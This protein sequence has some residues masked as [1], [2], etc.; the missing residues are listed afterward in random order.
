[1][2]PAVL[3][4]LSLVVTGILL[5]V[6]FGAVAAP[7]ATVDDAKTAG[8]GIRKLPGKR[9]T[10]YT[11]LSGAEIDQL[12]AVFEQAFPQW[13][14]YFGVQES[15]HPDWHMTGFLMKDKARFA[16]AGL[17]LEELPPFEHG[18]SAGL[19]LWLYEQPSDY[20]RRHLLLHEG[21]HGFM[22][23]VLGGWGRLWYMEGMAEYLATH[24]WQ[25]GQ[26]TLGYM[27]RSREEVPQWG[28]IRIIQDAV[29][30]HRALK[31][32]VVT[33]FQPSPH[34]D[35]DLYAW[36]WA[37]ATL[38]DRHPRYQAR[39]RDL[40]RLVNQPD[41]QERFYGAF[42]ADWQELS[43]E[44]QLMVA[45]LEYGYDVARSTI[46]FKPGTVSPRPLG[47][48]KG[49]NAADSTADSPTFVSVVADRGWQNTGLRLEAG[50]N[51][52][53]KATGRY[54]IAR[55]TFRPHAGDEQPRRSAGLPAGEGPG[56]RATDASA[57]LGVW[58]CEPNGVSIR[59]YQGR[60]LGIL[61]AAVRPDNPPLGSTSVLLRP[62]VVGLG[63]T[64]S[65]TESGT[66]FLKINDSVGELDDN[67]GELKVEVRPE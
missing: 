23:S 22:N 26:L 48:K 56:E 15:D 13:C 28:R 39:F 64:L 59:Y 16:E 30:A 52:H 47:E 49:G 8:A 24:R 58:W 14:K 5:W 61:L 32:R 46:D 25:D 57:G 51:Y 9:L 36:C 60:P 29:A 2:K 45:N 44:W 12:P 41:F 40:I 34:R 50:A 20:Y 17:L 1:M 11:D 18:Y 67:A 7:V 35:T 65:P 63:T 66:L 43:E 19:K 3:S 4:R 6:S 37:A 42:E 33:E 38:L 53:L 10:L 31:L 27:P 21:T 54:Q 55:G 62:I